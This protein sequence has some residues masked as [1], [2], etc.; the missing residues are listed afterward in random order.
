MIN[1]TFRIGPCQASDSGLISSLFL[2]RTNAQ[3]S[4][5]VV[6]ATSHMR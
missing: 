4:A 1:T 6:A 2:V 5:L 3:G